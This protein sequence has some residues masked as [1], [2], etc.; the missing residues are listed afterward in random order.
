M[1]ESSI[2]KCHLLFR[3]GSG[4]GVPKDYRSGC[5]SLY[6]ILGFAILRKTLR[7]PSFSKDSPYLSC[8]NR[9][10]MRRAKR[11]LYLKALPVRMLKYAAHNRQLIPVHVL[12]KRKE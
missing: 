4:C 2:F 3:E 12:L 5:G 9:Y 8:K 11:Q 1:S 6:H 10:K 7:K